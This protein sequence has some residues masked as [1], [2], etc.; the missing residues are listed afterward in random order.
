[1]E[2]RPKTLVIIR[3]GETD[4]NRVAKR[5]RMGKQEVPENL[6]G[7]P[8]PMTWLSEDGVRQ[9]VEAGK[10][11]YHSPWVRAAQ[12]TDLILKQFSSDS[13]R[14]MRDNLYPCLPLVEQHPGQLDAGLGDTNEVNRRYQEYRQLVK[15]IGHFY[16]E[17]ADVENW[18]KVGMRALLFL[19]MI[20]RERHNGQSLLIVTHGITMILFRYILE[21]L[22]QE[23]AEE[24]EELD[25]PKNCGVYTYTWSEAKDA[26]DLVGRNETFYQAPTE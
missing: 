2:Y 24:V 9:A 1:M 3:H 25:H 7:V 21:G 23:Q 13:E 20:Y 10:A 17:C 8:N 11:V 4:W 19:Q 18:T 22:T 15:K 16:I 26:Y 14:R 12:T 6:R 5:V